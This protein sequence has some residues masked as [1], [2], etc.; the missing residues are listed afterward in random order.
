LFAEHVKSVD[1]KI[2]TI[3]VLFSFLG[4]G[5]IVVGFKS[6]FQGHTGEE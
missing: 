2:N 3:K 1:T 6:Q 5:G 4:V